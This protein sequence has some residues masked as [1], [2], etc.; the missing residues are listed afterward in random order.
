MAVPTFSEAAIRQRTTAESFRRGQSYHHRGAIT[1]LIQR[2]D[3]LEAE[4]EGSQYEPYR[5]RITFDEGG[6]TGAGCD[7]PS[8]K[9]PRPPRPQAQADGDVEGVRVNIASDNTGGKDA[10]DTEIRKSA[11]KDAGEIRCHRDA[12]GQGL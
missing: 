6:V 8:Q 12:H 11:Q 2:G 7:C 5:V 10:Q 4:V 9:D 1:S 3:A